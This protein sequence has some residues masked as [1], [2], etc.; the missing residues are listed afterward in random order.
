MNAN[1]KRVRGARDAPVEP[2]SHFSR[3]SGDRHSCS[4][5]FLS[6]R[7]T[8]YAPAY[9][10]GSLTVSRLRPFFRR[11]LSTSLPHLSDILV[12]NP[13][14]L[15]RR[16]F[17]GLYVGLPINSYSDFRK[18]RSF[19]DK[20]LKLTGTRRYIKA[21]LGPSLRQRS[22]FDFSTLSLYVP[23]PHPPPEAF[24]SPSCS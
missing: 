2:A 12:R 15:I 22:L 23:P 9:F 17:R 7:K 1:G 4:G 21:S 13:C 11:R 16:L 6:N 8:L 10:V 3:P 20:S 14:V 5:D 24:H 19:A 18:F